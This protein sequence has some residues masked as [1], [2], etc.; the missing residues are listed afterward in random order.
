DG[1][2]QRVA[3]D[4]APAMA[5]VDLAVLPP[6]RR[7]EAGVAVLYE[8]TRQHFDLARGPLVRMALV[9]LG[10]RE[11]LYLLTLHHLVTDWITFQIFFRELLV[12]YELRRAAGA[13]GRAAPPA[14]APG[15]GAEA[16]SGAEP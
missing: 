14:G 1:P 8:H 2:V 7:E 10:E 16:W 11:H 13:R 6:A 9:R 15:T 3:A 4:L 12:A 5:L